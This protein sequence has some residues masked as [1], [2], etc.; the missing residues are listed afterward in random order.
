M[1]KPK[2]MEADDEEEPSED[3]DELSYRQD[4]QREV[5]KEPKKFPTQPQAQPQPEKQKVELTQEDIIALIKDYHN[6]T[7]ALLE[8]L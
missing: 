3:E 1:Y 8:Y 7:A 4:I 5:I 2:K 6:K